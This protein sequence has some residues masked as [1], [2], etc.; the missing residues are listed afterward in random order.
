M[1]WEPPQATFCSAPAAQNAKN[2]LQS[3]QRLPN[4]GIAMPVPRQLPQRLHPKDG[5]VILEHA[6]RLELE[7]YRLQA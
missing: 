3:T 1:A 5:T 6:Y 7:R 4:L 2:Q